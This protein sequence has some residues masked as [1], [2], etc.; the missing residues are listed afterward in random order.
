MP[1]TTY[2]LRL[3]PD[4]NFTIQFYVAP[5]T[6]TP[7]IPLF[8]FSFLDYC[9]QLATLLCL[10]DRI[11]TRPVA[12]CYSM[13][14]HSNTTPTPTPTAIS[15][16]HRGSSLSISAVRPSLLVPLP[17]AWGWS[18]LISPNECLAGCPSTFP[19]CWPMQ[20]STRFSISLRPNEIVTVW[21]SLLHLYLHLLRLL[22]PACP[23]RH[24]YGLLA[25]YL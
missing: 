11:P 13:P 14:S 24:S 4:F 17:A 6:Y 21:L 10:C 18:C 5:V 25:R 15:R 2:L 7:H 12:C 16:Q 23:D 9:A 19:R 20:F 8:N 22:L 1:F 3:L